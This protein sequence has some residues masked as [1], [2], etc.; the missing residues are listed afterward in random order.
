[1]RTWSARNHHRLRRNPQHFGSECQNFGEADRLVHLAVSPIRFDEFPQPDPL[2]PVQ[3]APPPGRA[4]F[5]YCSSVG[6]PISQHH[7]DVF[8]FQE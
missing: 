5:A 4:T 8:A 1:M 7:G 6:D 3:T 2:R